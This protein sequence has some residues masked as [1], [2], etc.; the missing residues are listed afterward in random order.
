MQEFEENQKIPVAGS[1]ITVTSSSVTMSSASYMHL[2][3]NVRFELDQLELEWLEG[4]LTQKGY[5]KKKNKLLAPYSGLLNS[6]S[7]AEA[8]S[9]EGK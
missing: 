4:D 6:S 5:E 3:P 7:V 2:P 9:S 1:P 8:N